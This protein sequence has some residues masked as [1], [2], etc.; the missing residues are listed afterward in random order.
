LVTYQPAAGFSGTDSFQYTV[1]D[2]L[3][4]QSNAASVS[5]RVQPAPV[6]ANDTATIPA[7]QSATL[8]VLGNDTSDAGT[9][10]S[11]SINITVPPAHGTAVVTNGAVVYTPATGYSGLDTFQ[12]SAKDNLGTVSNVATVSMDVTAPASGGKGGGG[13]MDVLDLLALAGFLAGTLTARDRVRRCA[14]GSSR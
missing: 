10:D 13:A 11:A 14:R 6:A 3:G 12:Y 2:G 8:N 9:L 4:G 5:V 7:N 1:L